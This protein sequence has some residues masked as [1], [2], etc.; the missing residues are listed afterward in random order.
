MNPPSKCDLLRERWISMIEQ[1]YDELTDLLWQRE[2][3]RML[4]KMIDGNHQLT[5]SDKPF[6]WDARRWYMVFAA[7][8]IRRQTDRGKRL[9]SLTQLL[10]ELKG[11]SHCI[12]RDTIVA[13][14]REVYRQGDLD[15]ER[16][17]VDGLWSKWSNAN[18]DLN[19]ARIDA[20]LA[21]LKVESDNIYNF[22]SSTIAHTSRKAVG[23]TFNLTFNDLDRAIDHL[24]QLT[25]DY[26]SLLTGRGCNTLLP[27]AQFD[28]HQQ[29]SFAWKP[30]NK[31]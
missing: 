11:Q 29:F 17:I 16:D 25:I 3:I 12:V 18:G 10:T 31:P 19:V 2:E 14:F 28:W 1:V 8:S 13:Q 15:F 7:M 5:E 6:L 30:R 21:S 9:I 26:Y 27:V 23:K 20:D 4:G 24:E 22:A